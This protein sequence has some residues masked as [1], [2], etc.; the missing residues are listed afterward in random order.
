MVPLY[1]PFTLDEEDQSA[2]TPIFFSGINVYLQQKS[3]VFQSAPDWFHR[4][5]SSR[6]LLKWLGKKA[7]GTRPEAL[8]ELTLSMLRGEEG[9][10]SRE[11]D[12]LIAWL[13]NRPRADVI[14]LSTA[15]LIGLARRL[16]SELGVPIM[17]MFQGEDGFLD[18]LPQPFSD[19]CWKELAARANEINLL[20]A[21]SRYFGDL[22]A[23]RLSLDPQ[24]VPVVP[25]GIN[26]SGFDLESKLK[27]PENTAAPVLGYFARMCPDK[28]LD[29]LVDAFIEI[30]RRKRVQNLQLRCGGSCGPGDEPFVATLRQKLHSNGL[31]SDFEFR[32][33]LDRAG[34]ISFLR[35][36]SVFSVPARCAEAFGLYVIE[37][38]AA[39]VPVVQPRSGAFPEL[40]EA[41][42]GGLLYDPKK[43]SAL[44]D[45]LE[46]LLLKPDQQRTLGEAGRA[47]VVKK[48]S[49]QAMAEQMVKVWEQVVR[50]SH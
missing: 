44:A 11:L 2:G 43:S 50:G 3:P 28:G 47:A 21:P 1:L 27:G 13:K 16:R 22:M 49:A 14:C 26:L 6:K 19:Q 39:G 18:A 41:T 8:G 46:D 40:V 38:L 48:F 12:E 30:G 35:S 24:M 9:N 45:T 23:R 4:L 20:A 36:A 10:Q 7:A 17:C 29:L 5:M 37:A 25:N 33:N 42:G 32:P 31:G 34:K 15:L